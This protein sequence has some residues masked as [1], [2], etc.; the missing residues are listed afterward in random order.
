MIP[1]VILAGFVLDCLV[2]DPVFALHPVRI[3][4]RLAAAVEKLL[5]PRARTASRAILFIAGAVAWIIV[6]GSA[7]CAAWFLPRAAAL[8]HPVAGDLVAAFF[9]WASIAPRDLAG[10]ALAVKRCLDAHSL[11]GAR[12]AVSM[13]VGR[14]TQR[15]DEAGVARACIESVAESAVD[16]VLA[17]LFWAFVLGPAGAFAYR[18]ANTL[19]SMF[20]HR[21]ERYL[22][23]GKFSARADDVATFLPARLAGPFTAIAALLVGLR[24]IGA[25]R[26]FFRDRLRHESPNA[27]H[28]EAA[29]AGALGTKL[30]GP[31]WYKGEFIDHPVLDGGSQVPDAAM[32]GKA[33]ALMYALS[34]VGLAI[35]T[36]AVIILG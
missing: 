3:L 12:K 33:V 22:Y 32:T 15:L 9:V 26:C 31:A 25:L 17:P 6:T 36:A 27:G 23:F 29:F 7:F 18:A 28:G 20:G 5:Y 30:G 11:P 14:D 13:I 2:G 19:D 10:H 34:V 1:W 24:G 21:T 4:G 35:G 16:G 8:I